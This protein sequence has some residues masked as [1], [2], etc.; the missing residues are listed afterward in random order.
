MISRNQSFLAVRKLG[1]GGGVRFR[2]LLTLF[3]LIVTPGL[4]GY[5]GV[6]LIL[7]DNSGAGGF[8]DWIA[9][10]LCL[11]ASVHLL[12]FYSLWRDDVNGLIRGNKHRTGGRSTL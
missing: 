2:S 10:L 3:F 8:T 11:M 6:D 1:G 7:N 9:G 5:A 12:V 4:L